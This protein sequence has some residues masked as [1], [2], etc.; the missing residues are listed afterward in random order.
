LGFIFL[1]HLFE[2]LELTDLI[3]I[4]IGFYNI[5]HELIKLYRK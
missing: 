2:L 4:E 1:M 3:I 5:S